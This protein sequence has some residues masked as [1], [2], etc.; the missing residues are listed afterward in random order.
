MLWP[1]G[2][3]RCVGHPT[4]NTRYSLEPEAFK[5]DGEGETDA[6]WAARVDGAW[7][8]DPA[9]EVEILTQSVERIILLLLMRP[10][11]QIQHFQ[12]MTYKTN[13]TW[14]HHYK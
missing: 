6:E 2:K 3:G 14:R 5:D 9:A 1:D 7:R 13:S 12:P 11:M 8:A 10:Q 4:H